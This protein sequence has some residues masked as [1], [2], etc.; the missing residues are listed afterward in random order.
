MIVIITAFRLNAT[1]AENQYSGDVAENIIHKPTLSSGKASLFLRFKNATTYVIRSEILYVCPSSTYYREHDPS[2]FKIKCKHNYKR[3][4]HNASYIWTL[5]DLIL[6]WFYNLP[7]HRV[8]VIYKQAGVFAIDSEMK[9]WKSYD[10]GTIS[11]SRK[12]YQTRRETPLK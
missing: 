4:P 11:I 6:N 1:T 7:P 5:S 8:T 9:T 2:P 12:H 10:I 3:P